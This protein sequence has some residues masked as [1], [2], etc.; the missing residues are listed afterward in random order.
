MLISDA[1]T[2]IKIAV[3]GIKR[4]GRSTQGVIVVRP[5]EGEQVSSLA[6]VAAGEDEATEDGIPETSAVHAEPTGNGSGEL[7]PLDEVD[8]PEDVDE[9]DED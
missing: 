6:L 7:A 4:S 2:V 8:E 3:D 1:G 9:A 5:R